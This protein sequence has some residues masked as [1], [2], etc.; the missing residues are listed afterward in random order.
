VAFLVVLAHAAEAQLAPAGTLR[1]TF[2]ASNPVQG[3]VDPKTGA[4]SGPGPD[5]AREMGRRLGVP[6]VVTPLADAGAVM[7]SVRDG[8]ADMGF[9]AYEAARAAQVDFSDPYL[10]MGSA[11]AVRADSMFRRTADVDRPGVVIGAVT[12]QSQEIWV[13][14]NVKSARIEAT[15]TVPPIPVLAELLLTGKI[16]AFA[17]NRTRMEELAREYPAIRVLADNF[18]T[19]GQAIIVRKN[20]RARLAE[21]NRLLAEIRASDFVKAS[22][23]RANLS[24]VEVA[25][26]PN[27]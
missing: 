25:P 11:Y 13:R 24:G 15:A 21:V 17:A 26:A 9:L 6:V 16:H 8:Q 4:T 20:D 19:V 5:L 1:A 2:I 3:R 10:L 23:A 7:A 18:A 22:I 14:E 27:R 12:G